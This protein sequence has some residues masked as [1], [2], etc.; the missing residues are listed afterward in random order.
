VRLRAGKGDPGPFLEALA[1]SFAPYASKRGIALRTRMGGVRDLY[2]D[3]QILEIIVSNLLSNACKFTQAGGEVIVTLSESGD[4]KTAFV[5]VKD[6]GI[7]IPPDELELIFDRFYQVDGS[8]ARKQEGTGIG[9]SLARELAAMHGGD[10]EARSAPGAG[11]EFI[12]SLPEGKEHLA[13]EEIARDEMPADAGFPYA[14]LDSAGLM[15]LIPLRR[16]EEAPP[17]GEGEGSIL[18]VDDNADMREYVRKG[19]EPR[20]RVTE[21]ADGAEALAKARESP[22][23]LIICDVMM[24]GMDGFE[25]CRAVRSDPKLRMIPVILLTARASHEMAMKGLEAG[26]VDYIT[27]PFSFGILSAKVQ[28]ILRRDAERDKEAQ[29]D[30]LTGLLNRAA[31]AREA[32][33][34][35]GRLPD[36]GQTASLAFLDLDDFK[37]AND[38]WG[39]RTGDAI[40]VALAGVLAKDLRATDLAGRYGGEEFV[41]FLPASS[42]DTAVRTLERTLEEF[43]A[44]VIADG[45]P[46]CSFSAGVV[47]IETAGDAKL[48]DYV[49][50]ADTAMYRAKL[51]G[52][53]RVTLW[54]RSMAEP[55]ADRRR[56]SRSE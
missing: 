51:A 47:E 32:D 5:S 48:D 22:P 2:F 1:R 36:E 10:I 53:S 30:G 31:W 42:G 9:L 15:S 25:F 38:A 3:R 29:R 50:R 34:E 44:A 12:L 13:E 11:S 7:G 35:F 4:G 45:L 46:P 6:T 33:R 20:F 17:A 40:L 16:D 23:R 49:F 37:A 55:R 18:V 27:K 54:N 28:G 43:R 26:A 52:K 8:L 56:D 14:R 19:I 24:P 21:A 41:L 39:H